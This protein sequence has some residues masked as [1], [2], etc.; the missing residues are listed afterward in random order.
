MHLSKNINFIENSFLLLKFFV[1]IQLTKHFLNFVLVI[2]DFYSLCEIVESE[3]RRLRPQ[4]SCNSNPRLTKNVLSF[5]QFD[6]ILK[7]RKLN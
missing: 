1:L 6:R 2:M 7:M 3:T 5:K 4:R